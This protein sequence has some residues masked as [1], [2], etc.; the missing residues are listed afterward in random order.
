[1]LKK[2]ICKFGVQEKKQYREMNHYRKNLTFVSA[3]AILF[4]FVNLSL[5]VCDI[6]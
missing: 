3:G 1:M 4:L 5:V 6:I 2:Y